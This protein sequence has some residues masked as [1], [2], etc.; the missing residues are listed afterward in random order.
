MKKI[1]TKNEK[2]TFSLAESLGK[3]IKA[4]TIF[5]L[6]GDLGTGKTVFAKGLARGLGVKK[7]ILSPTF[8]LMKIYPTRDNKYIKEFCHIDTYRLKNE[9]DLLAIGADEYLKKKNVVVAIEWPEK[10]K[11]ILPRGIKLVKLKHLEEE[12]RQIEIK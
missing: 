2:E 3:E 11:K 7:V 4:K 12:K 8:V 6:E 9:K 10:I 1:I 5:A